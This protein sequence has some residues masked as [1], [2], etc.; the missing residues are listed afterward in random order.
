[1]LIVVY[2]CLKKLFWRFCSVPFVSHPYCFPCVLEETRTTKTAVTFRS[3]FCFTL[4][5]HLFHIPEKVSF[6]IYFS[7]RMNIWNP[8]HTMWG[9]MSMKWHSLNPNLSQQVC[10]HMSFS[11]HPGFTP[12]SIPLIYS[13]SPDPVW[14][15]LPIHLP[16]SMAAHPSTLRFSFIHCL[17]ISCLMLPA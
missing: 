6:D 5:L 3:I 4:F 13:L 12:L 8:C 14:S 11:L 9:V 10:L 2:A 16:S 1:M 7:N 15:C 17:L